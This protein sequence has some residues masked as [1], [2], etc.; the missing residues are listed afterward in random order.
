LVTSKKM[1]ERASDLRLTA[2]R[3]IAAL[4]E[5]VARLD[6]A[7]MRLP[8][9][10][11][12]KLGDGTVAASAQHAGDNY[13]QIAMFLHTGDRMSAPHASHRHRGHRTPRFLGAF[14]HAPPGHARDEHAHDARPHD[15]GVPGHR[16]ADEAYAVDSFDPRTLLEQLSGSRRELEQ[17]GRLSDNQLDAI[18][19][20]GSFKFCDGQRTLD[21]VLASLLKHQSHQI[22]AIA[23][24]LS[25]R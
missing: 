2:D 24:A 7:T 1:T 14:G 22:D 25:G 19:P 21:Q 8:C 12:Q 18:P 11:R 23:A 16:P 3:Q 17:I 10:G 13:Q 15:D 5:L 9:P 6:D 20:E 4:I